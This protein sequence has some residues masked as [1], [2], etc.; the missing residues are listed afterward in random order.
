MLSF[1][2]IATAVIT[3]AIL[4]VTELVINKVIAK[5]PEQ[6]DLSLNIIFSKAVGSKDRNAGVTEL[7]INLFFNSI[8]RTAKDYYKSFIN[9]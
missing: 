1:T 9:R 5:S 2:V 6:V 4:L 7:F 3:R 8:T